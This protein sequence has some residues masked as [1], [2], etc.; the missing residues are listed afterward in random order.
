MSSRAIKLKDRIA[1][2]KNNPAIP[3]YWGRD[4]Q[5][6]VA[7]EELSEQEKV[8]A[9]IRWLEAAQDA[10]AHAERLSEIQVHKQ[11]SARILEPFL[12]QTNVITSTEWDNMFKQRIHPDAQPEFR[13][14][15]IKIK[16][17]MKNSTPKF[18][19]LGEWHLPY[20]SRTD[21]EA[22]DIES[23]KKISVAR[24]A[25]TSYG[26]GKGW[27]AEKDLKLENRLFT[28]DPKHY[29]PY[30]MIATPTFM[31]LVEGN[32]TGWRQLR[33]LI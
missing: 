33:H 3:I 2:V 30:E 23:L 14:L 27:D 8:E 6:M 29:A 17:A 7:Y 11:T 12:W 31:P 19:N 1:E 26:K 20:I 15:A 22:Y 16:E 18:V 32:F 10:V 21:R 25:R 28:A 9:E 4:Q 5:G 24:V 13:E